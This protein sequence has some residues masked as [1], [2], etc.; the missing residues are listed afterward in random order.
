MPNLQQMLMGGAGAG[1]KYWINRWGKDVASAHIYWKA[2]DVDAS[3]N[4]Y[5]AGD[6]RSMAGGS[7]STQYGVFAKYNRE[8]S[9][10]FFRKIDTEQAENAF[11]GM[12]LSGSTAYLAGYQGSSNKK[13]APMLALNTSDGDIAWQ[14]WCSTDEANE[15]RVHTRDVTSDSSGNLYWVTR[16][17][18]YGDDFMVYKT[19]SSGALQWSSKI[20][21]PSSSESIDQMERIQL[22]SNGNVY[23]AGTRN[24]SSNSYDMAGFLVKLNSS[25][26]IQWAREL[27]STG[28]Y[29]NQS[30]YDMAIDS[31]DNIYCV[32]LDRQ[33]SSAPDRGFIY[34][35]NSS[36]TLQWQQYYGSG[37]NQSP[38]PS[39]N[40][41]LR[42]ITIDS[43]DYLYVAGENDYLGS[44][45]HIVKLD[46]SDGSIEWQRYWKYGTSLSGAQYLNIQRS[47]NL[48]IANDSLYI[49]G[50]DPQLN[51]RYNGVLA[52]LPLTPLT[53][54]VGDLW[55]F[56]SV[57]HT[58][59]TSTHTS[60]SP[61]FTSDALSGNACATTV[62]TNNEVASSADS[63]FS[64]R[65]IEE[66]EV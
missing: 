39:V 7:Y 63:Q 10:V 16:R 25:G 35:Y 55:K 23:I 66:I 47:T 15:G 40:Q 13:G 58:V 60:S 5:V 3:G 19:N 41:H 12:E 17:L 33:G 34:K 65:E 62:G 27:G 8:G 31:S 20:E 51:S 18:S 50:Q 28:S 54:D 9:N 32:G 22:D 44:S 37:T 2:M 42:T 49:C 30:I 21:R 43:D 57:S 46:S 14:M 29:Q 26:A 56:L 45:L 53:T 24:H 38:D 52:K 4:I 36:G 59:T 11:F 1:E 48:I 6:A 64:E 61:S